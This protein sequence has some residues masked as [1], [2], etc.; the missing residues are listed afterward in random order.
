MYEAYV[1]IYET[2]N[3]CV[4]TCNLSLSETEFLISGTLGSSFSSLISSDS[5]MLNFIFCS[6]ISEFLTQTIHQCS[7]GLM[8]M[9]ITFI[10]SIQLCFPNLTLWVL[11]D[12]ER[13]NQI[14]YQEY[15]ELRYISLS[16]VS[17]PINK[18]KPSFIL[19]S[20]F[21]KCL[22]QL[23]SLTFLCHPFF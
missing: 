15:W 9:L 14:F 10:W 22:K 16:H 21:F 4:L 7:Q 12:I 11:S 8:E 1:H 19:D 3:M 17:F 5:S 13:T 6:V 18:N 23:S 2:W 20:N